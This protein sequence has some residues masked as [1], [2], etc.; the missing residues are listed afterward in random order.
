MYLHVGTHKTGTTAL[1]TSLQASRQLLL[2]QSILYPEGLY[3]GGHH[4]I[5][6]YIKNNSYLNL[7]EIFFE[8]INSECQQKNINKVVISS[9]DFFKFTRADIRREKAE[10]AEESLE[11]MYKLK[12]VLPKGFD[13][14]IVAY[15]RRQDLAI[16]AKY[17]QRV[18]FKNNFTITAKE[19]RDEMMDD[20]TLNYDFLL[21]LWASV[22]GNEN[23]IVRVYEKQELPDGTVVDFLKKVLQITDENVIK[24]IAASSTMENPRLNR[25][26]LEYK[27]ILNMIY[28]DNPLDRNQL[29]LD[30]LQV[31]SEM[32]GSDNF[33]DLYSIEERRAILEHYSECNAHVAK[34]FLGREDGK[35]FSEFTEQEE[36]YIPYPGLSVEKAIEISHRLQNIKICRV[37]E[38]V[39][40][41]NDLVTSVQNFRVIRIFRKIFHQLKR[42][43]NSLLIH[44]IEKSGL[45]DQEYYLNTYPEVKITGMDPLTHYMEYGW[46]EEFNPS[47]KFNTSIYLRRFPELR[48]SGYC[49]LVHYLRG[50][51]RFRNQSNVDAIEEIDQEDY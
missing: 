46:R 44:R 24:Q 45:F 6:R 35:L 29:Y 12:E 18:K 50:K 2:D 21:D 41:L 48:S 26:L 16:E 27:R 7:V 23:I 17:N 43:Q 28:K 19:F 31:A 3:W 25:D 10:I 30:F 40:Y 13:I 36:N 39:D 22:F 47:R 4:D 49:P 5:A 14:K 38:K 34:I 33:K 32:E 42:S 51:N 37:K 9:E 20:I 8:N 15:I 1:Q 11:N